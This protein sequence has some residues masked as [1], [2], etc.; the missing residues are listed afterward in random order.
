[1]WS[2]ISPQEL[3]DL[4]EKSQE[5]VTLLDVREPYE[6]DYGHLSAIHIPL[7]ELADRYNEVPRSGTVVVYCRS[8]SRSLQAIKYLATQHAFTNLVNLRGGLLG[9]KLDVDPD[10]AVY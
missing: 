4:L 3:K 2:E 8:G 10:I 6:Y 7:G 1:M 9:W 5:G